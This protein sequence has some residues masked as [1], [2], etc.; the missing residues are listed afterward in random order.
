M[1]EIFKL[2]DESWDKLVKE[3][4]FTYRQLSNWAKYKKLHN[5]SNLKIIYSSKN[6][7]V[8]YANV[9]FK[10]KFSVIFIYVPGGLK[11]NKNIDEL[12]KFVKKV[13]NCGF[14]YIRIDDNKPVTN[15]DKK[16]NIFKENN[17]KECLFKNN[18]F[19]QSLR[20]E[21]IKNSFEKLNLI[22]S[23]WRYN[24]KK[25]LKNNK[26]FIKTEENPSINDLNRISNEME[27]NKKIK[28]IHSMEEVH[29][30]LKF[31]KKE[32][33]IKTAY[34][35]NELVGFR[36]AFL[37]ENIG[38]DIYGATSN[39]GRKLKAGYLLLW[40]IIEDC[41]KNKIETY[42]LGGLYDFK[43]RHF[44]MGLTDKVIEYYGEYEK[45]NI[46]FLDYLISLTFKIRGTQFLNQ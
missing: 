8:N 5:W 6:K 40:S 2:S 27:K 7:I 11:E 21:L 10:K 15:F 14:F 22:D 42:D 3:N 9:F 12:I 43:M 26:I 29:N 30:M 44:K 28:Q 45:T 46:L 16:N 24:Y 18:K 1:W 36:M 25:A 13:N 23:K 35:N 31:F 37:F 39:D 34:Y 17:F 41:Y 38:W 19:N 20:I 4:T 32:L 33:I